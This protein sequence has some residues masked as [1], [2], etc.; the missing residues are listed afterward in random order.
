MRPLKL[1]EENISIMFSSINC[2][3]I[4]LDQSP[5]AKEIKANIKWDLIK[6]KTFCIA[7]KTINKRK[8]LGENLC[9][10]YDQPTV[11]I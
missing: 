9:K 10:G 11:H 7:N 6:F 8:R 4:V 3:N 2:G 1:L 5:K